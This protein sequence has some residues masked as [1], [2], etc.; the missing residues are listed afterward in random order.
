[1]LRTGYHSTMKLIHL[2]LALAIFLPG[3][4]AD[5]LP[6]LGEASQA[7]LSPDQERRVGE[8]VMNDI[9][10]SRDLFDDAEV[11]DYLNA[12][13]A[14]LVANSEDPSRNFE[15]F[16]LNDSTLN[17]FALPGGYIGVHTGLL[18]SAQNES[19]LASVL[20]H[21]I[22]HVTQHHLARVIA[23][24]Q[25]DA[26]TS[27]AALAVAI[28][29]SRS[30][31]Q[32][33]SAAIATAQATTLQNQLD[34]TREHER[35]ADRVG[36]QTLI[37]AGFDPHAMVAFFQRLQK[38]GR[39]YENNA[40]VYL[41][42]H[43]LTTERISDVENRVDPLPYRQVP[44]SLDFQ[45]VRA[46]LEATLDAPSQAVKIFEAGLAEK[47][48]SSET[49]QHYG[50]AYALL[51]AKNYARAEQQLQAARKNS[52]GSPI[53]DNLA[54]QIKSESGDAGGALESYRASLRRFP[55]WRALVYG[56]TELLLRSRRTAE[57]LSLIGDELKSRP[58]DYQLFQYQAEAFAAQGKAVQ[59]HRA[60][61]EAFLLRGNRPE[62]IQQL[63]IALKSGEKDFYQLSMAE[64][65]LRQLREQEKETGRK[66]KQ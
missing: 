18:L 65:R 49:A 47:K 16:V 30:N 48:Y 31:P 21:E 2:L 63:Q 4:R 43:P 37:R 7:I 12:L 52:P 55:H 29:A 38:Y 14:R 58:G 36:L 9:R 54:A 28:L 61:A 44:D 39:L 19:E 56:E 35:E 3:A 27:L 1:M 46:K 62:A 40:P 13:G 34:Y 64:A 59:Q 66:E 11:T 22:A 20:A 50:L 33:A 60:L 41:R 57:A 8:S 42:T 26:M 25:K 17:A 23:S 45:L 53:L 15:F 51:R 24:G 32:V 10:R 6:E 5:G